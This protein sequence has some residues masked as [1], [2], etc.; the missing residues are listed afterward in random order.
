M[1]C[2]YL[3]EVVMLY[4]QACPFH[5]GV[6]LDRLA[7]AGPCLALEYWQCPIYREARERALQERRVAT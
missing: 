4:C 2:P 6:P 5:K 7:S 1:P 3:K